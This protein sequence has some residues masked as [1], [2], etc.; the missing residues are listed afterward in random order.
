[1]R[2]RGQLT[3]KRNVRFHGKSEAAAAFTGRTA[4]RVKPVRPERQN[5][6]TGL[7]F[8]GTTTTAEAF[9]GAAGERAARAR[10]AEQATWYQEQHKIGASFNGETENAAAFKARQ[11][12]QSG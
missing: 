11:V 12:R 6:A 10:A 9:R 8:E 7:R 5:A 4:S 3:T 2:Q 1:M